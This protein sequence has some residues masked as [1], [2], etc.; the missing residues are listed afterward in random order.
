MT[1]TPI[2]TENT[3][4]NRMQKILKHN[5]VHSKQLKFTPRLLQAIKATPRLPPINLGNEKP[6]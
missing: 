6:I 1:T 2:N 4:Q 5:E 3:A